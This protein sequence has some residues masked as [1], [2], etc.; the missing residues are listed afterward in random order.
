MEKQEVWDC[1]EWAMMVVSII[2]RHVL[3]MR[4]MC[5]GGRVDDG[6]VAERLF[7]V[8]H[9]I[10]GRFLERLEGSVE[11]IFL[12]R[13]ICWIDD[14][15]CRRERGEVY[16]GMRLVNEMDRRRWD[17]DGVVTGECIVDGDD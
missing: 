13:R 2:V 10:R 3:R 4:S 7:V 14:E 16:G 15:L 12:N 9:R 6:Y 11:G 1:S 17:R 5:S 8:L